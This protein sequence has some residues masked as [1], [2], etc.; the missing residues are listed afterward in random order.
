MHLFAGVKS[1]YTCHSLYQLRLVHHHTAKQCASITRQSPCLTRSS[2]QSRHALF[3]P[4]VLGKWPC[5]LI[6]LFAR[7][8]CFSKLSA[9]FLL[10]FLSFISGEASIDDARVRLQLTVF[11]I[12]YDVSG[13]PRL[14][15]N[16]H[17]EFFICHS[18]QRSLLTFDLK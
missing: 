4:L 16:F 13:R 11:S 14:E 1:Y 10:D 15:G 5:P 18:I 7:F 3:S 8:F 6:P 9:L 17:A 2:V 12:W